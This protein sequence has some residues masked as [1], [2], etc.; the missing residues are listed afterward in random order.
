MF[1]FFSVATPRQ[2]GQR[3]WSQMISGVPRVSRG[4][5][6]R[7]GFV[8][9]VGGRGDFNGGAG[10]GFDEWGKRPGDDLDGPPSRMRKMDSSRFVLF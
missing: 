10:R 9:G 4:R 6:G 8:R 5:G 7:G 2:V 1:I 3:P